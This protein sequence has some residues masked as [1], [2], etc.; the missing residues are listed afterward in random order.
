MKNKKWYA[1]NDTLMSRFNIIKILNSQCDIG[2]NKTYGKK[3]DKC[4]V[5]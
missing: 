5:D 3:V 2:H 4:T 1:C